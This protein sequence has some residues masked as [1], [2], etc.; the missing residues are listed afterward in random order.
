MRGR[1]V[2]IGVFVSSDLIGKEL[3]RIGKEQEDIFR[4]SYESLDAAIAIGRQMQDEGVE[5]IVSRR[6]TA[7]LLREDLTIPV[8]SFPQSSLSTLTSIKMAADRLAGVE[9]GDV[10]GR[11]GGKLGRELGDAALLSEAAQKG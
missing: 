10:G 6:G 4:L 8:L 2:A 11:G 5:A 9:G 1:P 3:E 7:H